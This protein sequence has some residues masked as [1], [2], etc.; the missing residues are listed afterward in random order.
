MR[1][2]FDISLSEILDGSDLEDY[3]RS[4][5]ESKLTNDHSQTPPLN[6]EE[7]YQ[8]P[9]LKN[10]NIYHTSPEVL[11]NNES[12][13]LNEDVICINLT[14]SDEKYEDNRSCIRELNYSV[15]SSPINLKTSKDS[16]D[17][18]DENLEKCM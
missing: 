2:T 6:N 5:F 3:L 13:S 1:E 14:S 17:N 11:Y 12:P 4:K 18:D 8:A 7:I 9:P 16:S 15:I 10:D